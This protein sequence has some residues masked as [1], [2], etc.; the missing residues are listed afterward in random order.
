MMKVLM[1]MTMAVL[2]LLSALS[3]AGEVHPG[4]IIPQVKTYTLSEGRLTL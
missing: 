2:G 3:A 4:N 1:K